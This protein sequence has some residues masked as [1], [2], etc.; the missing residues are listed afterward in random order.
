MFRQRSADTYPSPH[1]KS[2]TKTWSKYAKV[3]FAKCF[4]Y[5]LSEIGNVQVEGTTSL[6]KVAL[7]C[8]M[9]LVS[10]NKKATRKLNAKERPAQNGELMSI[11]EKKKKLAHENK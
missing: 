7:H 9:L 1:P 8:V 3:Q 11:S 5:I 4:H 6:S 10:S 2:V